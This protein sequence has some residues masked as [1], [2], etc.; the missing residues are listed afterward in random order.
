MNCIY[1]DD[2]KEQ[3]TPQPL[4]GCSIKNWEWAESPLSCLLCH[5]WRPMLLRVPFWV[6]DVSECDSLD[7]DFNV[8]PVL[9]RKRSKPVS[10]CRYPLQL[11][12]KNKVLFILASAFLTEDTASSALIVTAVGNKKGKWG[13]PAYS[14]ATWKTISCFPCLHH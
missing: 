14:K 11:G 4:L 10:F 1:W 9:S 2:I 3:E 6:M 8:S 12:N 5:C 7:E 13:E